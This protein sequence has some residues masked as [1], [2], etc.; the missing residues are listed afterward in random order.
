[1]SE[2]EKWSTRFGVFAGLTLGMWFSAS[3]AAVLPA[4]TLFVLGGALVLPA[5]YCA[6]RAIR[7]RDSKP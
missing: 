3:W 4:W 7:I 2:S 5:S 1:M 6:D